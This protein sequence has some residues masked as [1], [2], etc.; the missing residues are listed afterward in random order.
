[1]IESLLLKKFWAQTGKKG[2]REEY[3]MSVRRKNHLQRI[4]A[5]K[6]KGRA[7]DIS[8]DIKSHL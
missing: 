1:M 4:L 7:F 2:R 6:I 5:I 3:Q 8:D